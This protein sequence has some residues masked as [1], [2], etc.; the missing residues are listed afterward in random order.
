MSTNPLSEIARSGSLRVA[1]NLD[2]P[3]L[4]S[5]R[6]PDGEPVGVAPDLARA[7]A[8]RLGTGVSYVSYSSPGAIIDGAADWDVCFIAADEKRAKVVAFAG[9]YAEIKATYLVWADSSYRTLEE[10]DQAGVRIAVAEASAYEL[11]LQRH[12]KAAQLVSAKGVAGSLALFF[13]EKLDVL[14]GLRPELLETAAAHPDCRVLD[15][16]YLTVRQSI[17]TKLENVATQSFLNGF[18]AEA[19]ESGLVGDLIRKYGVDSRL[20]VANGRP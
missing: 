15:G 4:V 14:A 5:G 17:G 19:V 9:A 20:S 3:L 8:D 7:A 12:L 16:D 13:S 6:S 2:N 10:V 1:I 11:F 18:V